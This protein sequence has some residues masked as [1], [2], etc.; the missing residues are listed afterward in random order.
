MFAPAAGT[1]P[2][3]WREYV[4]DAAKGLIRGLGSMNKHGK[5]FMSGFWSQEAGVAAGMAASGTAY[6]L[7][8][9]TTSTNRLFG[10]TKDFEKSVL[11]AAGARL[12]CKPFGASL[13][14][15][16]AGNIFSELPG[17]FGDAADA[18]LAG[19]AVN[20]GYNLLQPKTVKGKLTLQIDNIKGGYWANKISW[21]QVY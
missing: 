15:G 1:S 21:A 5:G 11:S 2:F 19:G 7:Q 12:G 13:I 14:P 3:G 10:I 18:K 16:L 17:I 8:L 4:D 20:A 6:L 9:P